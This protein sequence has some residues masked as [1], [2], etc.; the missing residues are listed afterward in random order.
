MAGICDQGLGT[1]HVHGVGTC[2]ATVLLMIRAPTFHLIDNAFW[3][4]VVM[5]AAMASTA[6]AIIYSP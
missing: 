1:W 4:R 3:K 6:V 5:A 2:V